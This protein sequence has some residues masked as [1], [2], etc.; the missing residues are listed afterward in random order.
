MGRKAGPEGISATLFSESGEVLCLLEAAQV[1]IRAA[2]A[3]IFRTNLF[4]VPTLVEARLSIEDPDSLAQMN[5]W[6]EDLFGQ[7]WVYFENLVI[8]MPEFFL[9]CR[10]AEWHDGRLRFLAEVA[11]SDNPARRIPAGGWL[12]SSDATLTLRQ[13]SGMPIPLIHKPEPEKTDE[14]PQP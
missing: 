14:N 5:Q 3:G 1:R 2:K 4:H 10:L 7:S 9:Q 6:T 11:L 8:E 13:A 12:D